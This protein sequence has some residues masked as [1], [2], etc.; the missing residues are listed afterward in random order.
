MHWNIQ[1]VTDYDWETDI[2]AL[3]AEL[4]DVQSALLAVLSDKRQALATG[5]H[6][7]L[8]AIAA[9][10]ETLVQRLQACHQRRQEL[11]ANAESEG[12][13]ADSIRSLTGQ[14]P[15]LSRQRLQAGISDA[16]NRSRI[17]QHQSLTNWVLV[18]RTLLHLSQM[19]EIIAT[20][21]RPKPTY[22]K[23]S[24]GQSSGALVDRA[25]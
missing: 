24:D 11:L 6:D 9:S 25:A 15:A 8:A 13:P 12:L 17:L 14:L 1:Q 7:A 5:N 18:Q 2:A 4:A 23:G 19:I 21:G 3:L 10:E 16:V 20:G 22:G